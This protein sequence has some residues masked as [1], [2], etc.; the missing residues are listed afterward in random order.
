M[1]LII[2]TSVLIEAERNTRDFNTF[3]EYGNAFISVIT[4]TELLMGVYKANYE[5]RRI[6]RH[7]FV[8][9]IISSITAIEFTSKDA[10]VYADILNT[11]SVNSITIGVHDLIIGA[12]AVSR[13]LPVLTLNASDFNRI[14]GV[15]V[16]QI[17][18]LN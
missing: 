18:N 14:P 3:Q 2:D 11:L 17:K 9:R 16:V 15:E 5:S 13:N 6:K 1:G 4:V 8:E 10:R 12:T 7:A